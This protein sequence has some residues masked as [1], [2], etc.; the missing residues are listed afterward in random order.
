MINDQI[1]L[2]GSENTI[3]YAD[4]WWSSLSLHGY[5]LTENLKVL[6]DDVSVDVISH[7]LAFPN[8]SIALLGQH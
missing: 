2:A 1:I 6:P 5:V 7:S 3:N 4:F 8:N